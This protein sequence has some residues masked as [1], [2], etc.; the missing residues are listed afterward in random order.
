MRELGYNFAF[1][2]ED[3]YSIDSIPEWA[4]N[5]LSD[6]TDDRRQSY[7]FE[8]IEAAETEDEV[9]NAA[10]RQL[11]EEGLIH[12]YLRM[13]WGKRI[14]SGLHPQRCCGLDDQTE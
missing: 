8:E 14:L 10:Q 5:T 2:R 9:W 13:L 12:N 1:H 4:S 7:T 3:H 6:H 11:K